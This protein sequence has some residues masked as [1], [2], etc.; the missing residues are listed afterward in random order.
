M[1]GYYGSAITRIFSGFCKPFD[2]KE[3]WNEKEIEFKI[4]I[5]PEGDLLIYNENLNRLQTAT[6]SPFCPRILCSRDKDH[7]RILVTE[8]FFPKA[9]IDL[10]T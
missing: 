1:D 8:V 4:E 3:R 7:V 10:H 5:P 6:K 2:L 9:E